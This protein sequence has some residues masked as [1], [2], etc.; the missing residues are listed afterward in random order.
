M[1][2]EFPAWKNR[3][4]M[5]LLREVEQRLFVGTPACIHSQD[6]G[7]VIDLDG[8]MSK[9][10]I[11]AYTRP[12]RLLRWPL[13]EHEPID[14]LLFDAACAFIDSTL[15]HAPMLVHSRRG[16]SRC[17]AVVYAWLRLQGRWHSTAMKRLTVRDA[18][19][20]EPNMESAWV[21]LEGKIGNK[22]ARWKK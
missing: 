17:G 11:D 22:K 19:I 9:I 13:L 7:G 18:H 5:Y 2:K 1:A 3:S 21:W 12:V 6:W 4:P 8:T 14:P 10:S 20:S 16:V 15:P